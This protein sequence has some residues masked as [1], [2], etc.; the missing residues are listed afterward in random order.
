[1]AV[2]KLLPP[3]FAKIHPRTRTPVFPTILTGLLAALLCAVFPLNVLGELV[4]I[5]EGGGGCFD[6]IGTLL[7][8][9]IVCIGVLVLRPTPPPNVWRCCAERSRTCRGRSEPPSAP[10]RPCLGC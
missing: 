8:F 4:S 10:R 7:A 6:P 2:D 9:V 1:M 3:P 5:G